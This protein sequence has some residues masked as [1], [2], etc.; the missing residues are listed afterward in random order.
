MREKMKRDWNNIN[1]DSD[2]SIGDIG[3]PFV[4]HDRDMKAFRRSHSWP[5]KTA[6]PNSGFVELLWPRPIHNMTNE[7]RA[8]SGEGQWLLLLRQIEKIPIHRLSQN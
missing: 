6:R 5:V 7:L 3:N 4:Q 2:I 1:H 8:L